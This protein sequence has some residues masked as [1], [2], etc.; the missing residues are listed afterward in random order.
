MKTVI[1][2]LLW[3]VFVCGLSKLAAGQEYTVIMG[4]GTSVQ[5]LIPTRVDPTGYV[6]GANTV[7]KERHSRIWRSG[8][9]IFA[10]LPPYHIPIDATLDVFQT[11]GN[12]TG[13]TLL[14]ALNDVETTPD[15]NWTNQG[16]SPIGDE[17]YW[18]TWPTPLDNTPAAFPPDNEY[19]TFNV[20]AAIIS[21]WHSGANAWQQSIGFALKPGTANTFMIWEFTNGGQQ[22]TLTITHRL[23]GD[24]NG[25]LQF[26]SADLV[27]VFVAGKYETGQPAT[28]NEGDW[29]GDG[30]FT[31]QDFVR[32][33][34][35]DPPHYEN[36]AAAMMADWNEINE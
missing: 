20:F 10:Q 21:G 22:P 12:P 23:Y 30:F 32:A 35:F 31:S 17:G 8:S 27:T 7:G 15:E 26:N 33:F 14:Y 2:C 19:H 9:S 4:D 29:N 3:V 11:A 36:G 1:Y 24:S 13:E 6:Y 28:F 34:Q 18:N 25:D 5:E 16:T